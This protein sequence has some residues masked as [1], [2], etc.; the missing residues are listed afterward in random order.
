MP[1]ESGDNFDPL[2]SLD[3]Q[4]HVYGTATPAARTT[5]AACGLPLH[6]FAWTN[7]ARKA[8]LAKDA[9]YLIRPDGYVALAMAPDA[10]GLGE[11]VAKFGIKK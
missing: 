4:V 3:W 7:E 8:G 1:F 9:V 2:K 11:Y 10:A 6:E 5:V